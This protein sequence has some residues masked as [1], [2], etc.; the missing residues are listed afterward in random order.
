[1]F[2]GLHLERDHVQRKADMLQ[3]MNTG[4]DGSMTTTH[5]NSP[6]EACSR[7]ETLC[8]MSGLDLPQTAIRE[9]IASSVNLI[10]QIARLSDGSR[11]L[12]SITE[13]TGIEEDDGSVPLHPIFEFVRTGTTATGKV[14]GAF[15]APGDL[16]S[17]L[18]EFIVR[19]FIKPGE[20]YL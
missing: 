2:S 5:A 1:M 15:R 8:L 11:K 16:P 7:L 17:F 10:V 9:Q 12:M 19:G 13:V 6:R 3:A 18:D 14:E 20:R 4:H